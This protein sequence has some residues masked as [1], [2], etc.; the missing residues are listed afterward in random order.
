MTLY[1]VTLSV[2]ANEF[3][4]RRVILKMGFRSK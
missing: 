1:Y 4:V 3:N 2:F